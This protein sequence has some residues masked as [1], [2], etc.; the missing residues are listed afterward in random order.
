[1]RKELFDCNRCLIIPNG[2]K[3]KRYTFETLKIVN[4][5]VLGF[6]AVAI[7]LRDAEVAQLRCRN[8]YHLIERQRRFLYSDYSGKLVSLLKKNWSQLEC[9]CTEV[10]GYR[11]HL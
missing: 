8:G 10:G 7:L 9:K 1:M 3:G 2:H 6:R 4:S 5:E 11:P